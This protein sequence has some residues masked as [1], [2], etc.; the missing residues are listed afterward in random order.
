[1]LLVQGPHLENQSYNRIRLLPVL[2]ECRISMLSN[3]LLQVIQNSSCPNLSFHSSS[4]PTPGSINVLCLCPLDTIYSYFYRSSKTKC[5][6]VFD[7]N[8]IILPSLYI[9]P[10]TKKKK[11]HFYIHGFGQNTWHNGI[12]INAFLNGNSPQATSQKYFANA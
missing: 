3:F 5:P 6:T 12:I 7:Y 9:I 11:I 4:P 1:M 2:L 8:S 10:R